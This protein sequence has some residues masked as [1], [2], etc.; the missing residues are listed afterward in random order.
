MELY[1]DVKPVGKG[2]KGRTACGSAAY[3]SCDKIVDINGN[4]HNFKNK[5]GHIAGGIELPVGAP[6]ELRNPQ[7]LWQRHDLK[8]IRKDAQIY[9]EV[10]VALPNELPD[11]DCVD[12][13]KDLAAVLT[14]RGMCV[15]WD[16]HNPHDPKFK[17]DNTAK[18]EEALNEHPENKHGHL[19]L[20]LRE[21]LPD[22]T[23]GKKDRSWNKYNGGLNLADE[24]RPIAAQ[25]M[26]EKLE[27]YGK[28]KR[29]EYLSYIERGIDKIPQIKVGVAGTNIDRDGRVSYRKEMN[30]RIKEINERADMTFVEKQIALHEAR[31]EL[32]NTGATP[33]IKPSLFD[34]INVA[35]KEKEVKID[36]S[37]NKERADIAKYYSDI[38]EFNQKIF[39]LRKEKKDTDKYRDALHSYYNLVGDTNLTD[40][41]KVKLYWATGYLK[42]ALKV[43]VPP[44][45]EEVKVLINEARERN[46]ERCLGIYAA[47][48]GKRQLLQNI[49]ISKSNIEYIKN[50]GRFVIEP[51]L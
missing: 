12:I 5:R 8:E 7:V 21:L 25:L 32:A 41:Q 31:K 50:P 30:K 9:R 3:R 47:E 2:S 22:G 4:T 36:T 48:K 16:I 17:K 20:T 37:V 43:E 24:L 44:S 51:E 28:E 11:E 26:N 10:V 14:K 19:M 23:F 18:E 13:V 42:S 15:Q 49:E 45:K 1:L 40:E 29:V 46:T 33:E 38:R 35:D 34:M 27:L 6:S 39:D